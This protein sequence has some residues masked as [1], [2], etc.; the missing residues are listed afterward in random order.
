MDPTTHERLASL[1]E[2]STDDDQVLVASVLAGRQDDFA[3]LM[4]RHNQRVYR[5][6]RGVV[7]DDDEA[8]DVAQHAWLAA[9]RHLAQFEGRARFSTWLTRIAVHEALA[10]VKRGRRRREVVGQLAMESHL[11]ATPPDPE[12]LVARK[13][14]KRHL[15]HAIDQLPEHYRLVVVLRDVE[16]M[17]T[18]ETAEVLAIT[19][20]NVRVRLHRGRGM[21]REGL[22]SRLGGAEVAFHFA[23]ARCDRIVAGLFERLD[24]LR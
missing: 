18:V 8:E 9:Y 20:E 15:E 13:Q 21:L 11:R 2:H 5:A 22:L 14:L 7:R 4:R 3:V 19:E 23:G 24:Q 12:G 16:T 1:P 10:R 17:S 6:V